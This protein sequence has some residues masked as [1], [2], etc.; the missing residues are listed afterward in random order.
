MQ[1]LKKLFVVLMLAVSTLTS[2]AQSNKNNNDPDAAF[3]TAKEY[4]QKEQYSLAFPI[5][6]V[7][8]TKV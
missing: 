7:C 4:W 2:L 5:L 8:I 6:K 3:K 1:Q